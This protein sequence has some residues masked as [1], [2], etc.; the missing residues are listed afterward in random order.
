MS[1]TTEMKI[2]LYC[3]NPIAM[4][5]F[6]HIFEA[7]AKYRVEE[8]LSTDR[9]L[10]N[11]AQSQP[12]VVILDFDA[13]VDLL[14]LQRL[15]SCA[16]EAKLVL[17]TDS[18]GPEM[19]FHSFKLGVVG[20]LPKTLPPKEFLHRVHACLAGHI[21][22][23]K[24]LSDSVAMAS[25]VKLTKRESELV[26][27]V[28]QG[29]S[30][31]QIA[32]RLSITPFTV[33]SYLTRLFQRLNVDHRHGLAV[34]ALTNFTSDLCAIREKLNTTRADLSTAPAPQA[35]KAEYR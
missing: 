17:W 5:G 4:L 20:V 32:T 22:V 24:S 30:N 25:R 2:L 21:I 7:E 28:G 33:K 29:L 11:L 35:N 6:T 23:E 10:D 31:K 27:L 34:Y 8:V 26:V 3:Q 13:H 9:V 15:H 19:A 1:T 18:I 14:F 12:D 16:P